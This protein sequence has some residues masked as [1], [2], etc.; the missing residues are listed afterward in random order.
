MAHTST[1]ELAKALAVHLEVASVV[2]W[3]RKLRVWDETSDLHGAS[4]TYA[5]ARKMVG[6]EAPTRNRQA[7][8]MPYGDYA[9]IMAINGIKP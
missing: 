3:D 9:W 8:Q 1:K 6:H 7:R 5:A 4:Y 2:T